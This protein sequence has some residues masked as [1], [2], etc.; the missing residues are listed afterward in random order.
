MARFE[1]SKPLAIAMW[2]FSWLERRWPGAGYEDPGAALDELAERGYDAVRIDA[3]PHFHAHGPTTPRTVVPVWNQQ[4][5]GSPAKTTVQLQPALSEFI[6]ACRDRGIAVG[7][8]SW[9]QNDLDDLKRIIPSP[10]AHARQW[11]GVLDDLAEQDL[12]DT[13]LYVDLCNEWPVKNWALFFHLAHGDRDDNKFAAPHSVAWMAQATDLLRQHYPN[14]PLS[15][16][17]VGKP[18]AEPTD[19]LLTALDFYEPHL[20]VATAP[21][22][23][24]FYGAIDYSFQLHD[25]VGFENVVARA[26]KLYRADPAHWQKILTDE[27]DGAAEASRVTGKP[28]ITTECWGIVDYKD[29]PGL[30]WDWVKELCVVGTKHAASTGR[31]AAIA[32]SNF[33]GPQFVGMWRDID[34]HR[35]LTNTI[36]NASLPEE[37]VAATRL[38]AAAAQP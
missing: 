30:N 11:I 5:W 13:L 33:C 14:I 3:Y 34:W 35:E 2:D 16:S 32:T 29:W 19:E 12:L 17:N 31:W 4:T 15:F 27:I 7:L 1:L 28:L 25:P 20:W 9:Y 18:P 22:G 36:H 24:G 21:A 38:D 37:A 8:S 10:E 6:R 23:Q 26:E